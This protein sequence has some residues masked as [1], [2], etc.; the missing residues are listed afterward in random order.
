MHVDGERGVSAGPAERNS[1][2]TLSDWRETV[3]MS[4]K[5]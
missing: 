1:L 3:I 4:C 2:W 5:L